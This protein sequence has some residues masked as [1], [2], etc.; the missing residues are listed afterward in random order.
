MTTVGELIDYLLTQDDDAEVFIGHG[1]FTTEA[2]IEL[3]A[4]GPKT[5]VLWS[6]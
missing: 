6:E 4:S 1:G 5:V 2:I 3:Q